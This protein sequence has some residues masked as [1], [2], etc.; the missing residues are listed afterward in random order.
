MNIYKLNNINALSG[1]TAV[2]VGMF[3]GVHI[4][5]QHILQQ[6]NVEAQ[7]HNL[8]P[9]VVT[10]D[11]HPRQ[12]LGTGDASF[13]RITSNAERCALLQAHGIDHVV[14]I[15]FTPEV[16][17]LSA[18][19]FFE[20]IMLQKLNAKVLVL[21]Y[22]NVFGSKQHNDFDQ[23]PLLA[24]RHGVRLVHDSAVRLGDVDVSSTQIRLALGR[25]DV[26]LASTMMGHNYQLSGEVVKGRQVGRE[27]GFPT[28]NVCLSDKVKLMP[29]DGVYA[30]RV[31]LGHDQAPLMGMANLGGQPTFGLDKPVFEVH[32]FDFHESLYGQSLHVEFID[33]LR[34]VRRFENIDQLV[35]QL[36]A[37]QAAAR[38]VLA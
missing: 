15:H 32:I 6:L 2:T 9:V 13:Y 23:L 31:T 38:K 19:Q 5:H 34:D 18:C 25:G 3:D 17:A 16:A 7:E 35:S 29:A 21:G 30:V 36:N 26:R 11:M 24:S 10:F 33:K 1:P 12:V 22:D 27:L 28:A 8:T 20:Q 14:E 4:G 37:D